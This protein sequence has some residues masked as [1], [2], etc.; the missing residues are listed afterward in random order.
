MSPRVIMY[1]QTFTSLKPI[2][3][4]PS[5]VTHIHV[6][7][8]HF[9][10]DEKNKP[11]IHLNNYSPNH[12]TFDKVW[13]EI[14]QA[15]KLG[16]QVR[17]MIGGAGGGYATLFSDF[18]T[19]YSL[20]ANLL[21]SK[22]FISGVDLDI[23]EP[24]KIDDVRLLMRTIKEEF[25]DSIA[26]TMA[27]I[28]SS[29]ESDEPGMGGFVYKNLLQS[30]EGKLIEYFNTQFY[31][32][33]S[34][35]AFVKIVEN[36]YLPEMVVMGTLANTNKIGKEL[37]KTVQ[38]YNTNFG[39]VFVWEYCFAK[40]SPLEWAKHMNSIVNEDDDAG[41]ISKECPKLFAFLHQWSSNRNKIN[42]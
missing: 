12:Y 32:D 28:Q 19:F 5:P 37:A 39:G 11:Y 6:A 34:C 2:L 30:P 10:Y 24:C 4:S 16:I 14:E 15:T 36:G 29:L 42:V 18:K 33:F 21:R 20:L 17:L 41:L 23:E 35:D 13:D 27:P 25:G 40:P 22:S 26:L 31:S 9:G 1:Y 7:A 38:K 3:V 8:I